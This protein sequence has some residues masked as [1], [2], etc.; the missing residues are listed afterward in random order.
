MWQRGKKGKA[1]EQK[2]LQDKLGFLKNEP[3]DSDSCGGY[4]TT[5][6]KIKNRAGEGKWRGKV[7]TPHCPNT[8]AAHIA[9]SE[10]SKRAERQRYSGV[11]LRLWRQ[12]ICLQRG[13]SSRITV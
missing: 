6:H 1:K 4:I 10:R 5:N 3:E 13:Q 12:F 7:K 9:V 8:V 11:E 2:Q